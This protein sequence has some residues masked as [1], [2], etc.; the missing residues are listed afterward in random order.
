MATRMKVP[1]IYILIQFFSWPRNLQQFAHLG[2]DLHLNVPKPT[3]GLPSSWGDPANP[4]EK[5]LKVSIT[6]WWLNQ[7][8]WK[9][10]SSNWKSSRI[11]GCEQKKMFELP[12]TVAFHW[13]WEDK[14]SETSKM[15]C[16]RNL[17]RFGKFFLSPLSSWHGFFLVKNDPLRSLSIVRTAVRH[18]D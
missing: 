3:R 7:P 4:E 8:I 9:I 15:C 5:H 18:A 2:K 10:C 11:F 14:P 16:S 12:P 13:W 1:K 6:S 17:A